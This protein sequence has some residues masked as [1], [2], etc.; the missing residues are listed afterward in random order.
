MSVTSQAVG[1]SHEH[2][3]TGTAHTHPHTNTGLPNGVLGVMLFLCS[4]MALFGSLIF[5]YLYER[6]SAPLWPP[7]GW[8]AF[9][10]QL[11]TVNTV[12]L[13]SSGVT[14]HFA[15]QALRRGDVRRML[16]LL[17]LT[18]ILGVGF[19][20][21]QVYEYKHVQGGMALHGSV[22]GATFFTL[23]GLHGIHVSLGVVFLL[24]VLANTLR[25][26]YTATKNIVV[27]AAT[28]YWHFVDAVWVV[29][30]ALFYLTV[31]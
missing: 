20:S 19:L 12:V 16:I 7:P 29:L 2:A 10:W 27:H 15:F 21:G 3:P 24:I 28:L 14:M 1:G 17:V 9:E 13:L 22:F 5:M 25:G 26:K 23:T 11:P 4:E 6:R 30:F 31:R 8:H 18:I